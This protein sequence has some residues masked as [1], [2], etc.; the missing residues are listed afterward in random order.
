MSVSP[1]FLYACLLYNY[2]TDYSVLSSFRAICRKQFRKVTEPTVM[3]SFT[4]L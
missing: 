3:A 2:I 4:S 1:Q